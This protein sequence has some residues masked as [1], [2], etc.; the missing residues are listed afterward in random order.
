RGNHDYSTMQD[1]LG[2]QKQ[3]MRNTLQLNQGIAPSGDPIFS[4]IGYL[5]GV[6]RTD[7]SWAPLFADYDNDGLKDLFIANGYRKDV[8]NLDF[9]SYREDNYAPQFGTPEAKERKKLDDISTAMPEVK[10]PNFMYRNKGDLTFEDVSENWGFSL[11]TYSNGTIYADLDNDGD[12]DLVSNNIDDN[13]MLYENMLYQNNISPAKAANHYLRIKFAASQENMAKV[14]GTVVQLSANGEKQ[15]LEFNPYRGYKSTVEPFLH[16]GL[17]TSGVI[18]TITVIWPNQAISRQFNVA[19]NQLLTISYPETNEEAPI[20]QQPKVLTQQKKYLFEDMT[21]QAELQTV[22]HRGNYFIDFNVTPMLHKQLSMDG[23]YLAA[24]DLNN[25]GLEDVVMGGDAGAASKILWQQ[26]GGTFKTVAMPFD[27]LYEDQGILIF[28]ANGDGH[29]DIY[30]VSGGSQFEPNHIRHQDRLYLNDGSGNF[31]HATTSLPKIG[32]AGSVVKGADM[33]GDG[34]IDLFV[35][36]RLVPKEY[37]LPASSHLLRNDG[38]TFVDVTREYAPELE[39]LG[40]VTD[41]IW[42]DYDNSGSPDLVVVGEW[43][44]VTVF[45][46]TKG[47][48][49]NTTATLGLEETHGL[50]YSVQA[51]DINQDGYADLVLGNSGLNSYY[52]ASKEQPLEIFA[53]DFDANGTIDPILTHYNQDKRYISLFRDRMHD[54]ILGIKKRFKRYEDF[55]RATFDEAF[56]KKEMEGVYHGKCTNLASFVLENKEGK[57]FQYHQLPAEAQFST[58]RS[59]EVADMDGDGHQDLLIVGNSY[60][61]ESVRGWFDASYGYFLS[62]NSDFTFKA[63]MPSVSGF[64]ASGDTRQMIAIMVNSKKHFIISRNNGPVSIIRISGE[65]SSIPQLA[66]KNPY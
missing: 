55:G 54:Q 22:A 14:D 45:S 64:V 35:G 10:I 34:D 44:L 52:T 58:V 20:R 41:A 26:Q 18:D 23:P 37:P 24:G 27:S 28:D 66:N 61:E 19:A 56:T 3:Y 4:E 13:A 46:N 50:Y 48:L 40:L 60:A 1:K 42:F 11:P 49:T 36:G 53:K 25:D 30:I 59:I 62:G 65:S 16:F 63:V 8:T 57:T 17:G 9:A 51:A 6:F 38:G 7:W 39:A 2:Y 43:M 29:N 15:Y 12:L 5:A 33:D 31:A 21:L 47:R 32:T